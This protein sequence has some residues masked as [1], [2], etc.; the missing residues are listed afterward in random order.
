MAAVT[1]QNYSRVK[2][3][4]EGEDLN[5]LGSLQCFL[6]ETLSGAIHDTITEDDLHDW[7]FGS[8]HRLGKLPP[9]MTPAQLK[10]RIESMLTMLGAPSEAPKTKHAISKEFD[11]RVHID[12]LGEHNDGVWECDHHHKRIMEQCKEMARSMSMLI[13]CRPPGV[14]VTMIVIPSEDPFYDPD[15]LMIV[16][17][18]KVRIMERIVP[19]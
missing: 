9:N 17:F 10:A 8:E 14:P 2:S 7:T 4:L 15:E 13:H 19:V 11:L 5:A 12:A 3:I 16:F 18:V 6:H 1:A